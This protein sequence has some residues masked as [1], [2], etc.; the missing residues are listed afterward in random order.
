[1]R[2]SEKLLVSGVGIAISALLWIDTSLLVLLIQFSAGA[3]IML[4]SL[5]Y[6]SKNK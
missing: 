5:N 4:L 3:T 6:L 1:M 2:K